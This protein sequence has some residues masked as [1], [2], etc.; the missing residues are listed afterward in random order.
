MKNLKIKVIV[1]SAIA[2]GWITF[3]HALK[4]YAETNMSAKGRAEKMKE[5]II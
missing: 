2:R 4:F 5:K 1:T 3:G